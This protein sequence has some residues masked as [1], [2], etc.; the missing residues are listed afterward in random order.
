MEKLSPVGRLTVDTLRTLAKRRA[1]SF[2]TRS[3]PPSSRSSKRAGTGS[4]PSETFRPRP[5]R[6]RST[7]SS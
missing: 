4:P 5:S 6:P 7:A 2:P 1:S 3:W